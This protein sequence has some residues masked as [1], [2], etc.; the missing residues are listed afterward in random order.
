MTNTEQIALDK[1]ANNE[2]EIYALLKQRYSPRIFDDRPIEESELQRLFEAVRW[3][4]SSYNRQPWRFIFA[5]KGSEAYDNM[6]ECLSEFNQKWAKNAPVLILSA[7][8]EKTK[9][10]DENFHALHDLGLSLGNMT[11]QAQY[12]GIAL[13]HM[14]G[15]DWKKAQEVFNVPDG[16]HITTAIA[17][18]YYGGDLDNL[19]DD[20]REQEM[21]ERERMPQDEFAF[22]NEWE[23]SKTK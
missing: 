19:N 23:A 12:M 8:K 14:A 11:V 9:E 16:Y 10:G 2:H 4:A 21:E 20:L 13:H 3:A 5:H 22:E 17:V 6:L 7:Y 15:V 18:G 1:I